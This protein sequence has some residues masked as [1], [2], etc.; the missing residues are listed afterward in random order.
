[1]QDPPVSLL[2]GLFRDIGENERAAELA[3]S[4]QP[5]LYSVV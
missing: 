1:M 4:Q 5:K 2:V 3:T